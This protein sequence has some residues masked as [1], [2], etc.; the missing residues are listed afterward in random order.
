M[1]KI[2]IS[3]K[4]NDLNKNQ[5]IYL[6]LWHFFL[7]ISSIMG[8]NSVGSNLITKLQDNYR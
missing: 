5:K 2:Y 7:I 1:Y 4:F 6:H 8:E 3:T